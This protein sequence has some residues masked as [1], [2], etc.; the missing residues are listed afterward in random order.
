MPHREVALEPPLS[1]IWLFLE[2]T[3]H[4]LHPLVDRNLGLYYSKA[5]GILLSPT[6]GVALPKPTSVHVSPHRKW[7]TAVSQAYH[8]QLVVLR[9]RQMGGS[10]WPVGWL[11]LM[12]ETTGCPRMRQVRGWQ[13]PAGD[14]SVL[15]SRGHSQSVYYSELHGGEKVLWEL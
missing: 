13:I 1:Y 10:V 5:K 9:D 2:A 3:P 6:S 11:A 8:H 15:P 12:K 14:I 4:L 7:N